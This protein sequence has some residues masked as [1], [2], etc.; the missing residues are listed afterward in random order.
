MKE[1]FTLAEAIEKFGDESK[2]KAIISNKGN[3]KT[4]Q[5]NSLL[6]T[7]QQYYESVT[8][9][10]KGKRRVILCA[11]KRVEILD[12]KELLHYDN[13]GQG[14]I[15]YGYELHNAV[16]K[17]ILDNCKNNLKNISL[18]RWLI[19]TNI[20]DSRLGKA[21]WSEEER[22]RHIAQ[23]MKQYNDERNGVFLFTQSDIEVLE[24]FAS[25]ELKRLKRNI[26]SIFEKLADARI[27]IHKK[28]M[29]GC[30]IDNE[31]IEDEL[32]HRELT[33]NEIERLAN[34]RR[35]LL[36][37]HN[38]SLD[39]VGW[40]TRNKDVIAYKKEFG[41][42]LNEMGFKYIY[43][44]HG[45][46]VQ[47]SDKQIEKFIERLNKKGQLKYEHE[48][49]EEAFIAIIANFKKLYAEKSIELATERQNN[50]SGSKHIKQLKVFEEYVPM[51]EK[52]LIF[53]GLT[54]YHEAKINLIDDK[55]RI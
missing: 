29:F 48:L 4:N 17:H 23:L 39:E 38:V 40:K 1:L 43:E 9:E 51:W 26:G 35:E 18:T 21:S 10:G 53:Y 33:D 42:E 14:Q 55:D 22:K 50:E 11:G 34:L 44:T 47:V 2:K 3:L 54:N 45:C 16:L 46:V 20:I 36:R 28:S 27:I 52:L 5:F 7:M 25:F 49:N 30:P 12:R 41:I 15:K 8:V 37:K 24:Q 19:D 13:C 31:D 32:N 6:T